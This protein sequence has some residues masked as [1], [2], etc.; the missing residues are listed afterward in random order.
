MKKRS[1]FLTCCM[2]L[3]VFPAM[4]SL[5]A[6][7]SSS[8]GGGGSSSS[9]KAELNE[10]TLD[11]SMKWVDDNIAGC[12]LQEASALVLSVPRMKATAKKENMAFQ[13]VADVLLGRSTGGVRAMD[14]LPPMSGPIEG[15]CG[16]SLTIDEDHA[17]GNSD[18]SITFSNFCTEDAGEQ[19]RVDGTLTAS[20]KGEP[21]PTGPEIS[22]VAASTRGPLTV[23]TPEDTVS[24]ELDN[25]SLTGDA[26]GPESLNIDK[27]SVSSESEGVTHTMSNVSADMSENR[28]GNT[29]LDIHSGRYNAGEEGYVDISTPTPLTID[30]DGELVSGVINFEG[31]DGNTVAVTPSS[32]GIFDVYLNEERVDQR[33]DCTDISL[34][35]L[36]F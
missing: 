20:I 35:L 26:D 22:S 31:A 32:D 4:I 1:R 29:E 27:I 30:D 34:G 11:T 36:S 15:D 7:D 28:I 9:S 25:F 33:M 18:I 19:T 10:D 8:D 3:F 2:V 12:E 17:N 13:L 6:C 5:A 23:A 21:T 14:Y 16:G 24:I